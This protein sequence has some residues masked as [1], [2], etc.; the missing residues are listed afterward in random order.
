MNFQNV[1]DS[2]K[3]MTCIVSVEKLEG[4]GHGTIRIVTGNKAYIDSIE[5]PMDGVAMLTDKF[6]PNCEYTTYLPKDLNFEDFCYRSAVEKKCLHSYA[7]PDRFDVWF[8]MTFM[9][10]WPD[11]GNICYCTYSMEINQEADAARMSNISS[12]IAAAVLETCIMLRGTTNFIKTI[13]DIVGFVRSLCKGDR[14]CLITMDHVEKTVTVLGDDFDESLGVREVEEAFGDR[15]Y[16]IASTW[17]DTISGSNCLIV[18][19]QQEMEVVKERNPGWYESLV[20]AGVKTIVL[21]PLKYR[22]ELLGYMWVINFESSEAP[23]LK[24]ALEAASFILSSEIYNYLL[25][26]RLKTLSSKDMLTGVQN[27]NEMNNMVDSYVNGTAEYSDKSVGIIFADLNGLKAIN[28]NEGHVAGDEM[29]K[30]AAAVLAE[31]FDEDNIYRAGGDEFTIIAPGVTENDL[32]VKIDE[33]RTIAE[34]YEDVSFAMGYAVVENSA[35]IRT[36]LR[37]ADERMYVDKEAYYEKHPDKR[38]DA[39]R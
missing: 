19:D 24:E 7:H 29:L 26:G 34:K 31:V 9:P 37:K 14:C 6:V 22:L 30:D 16:E 21:F 27:R 38:R 39:T 11:D 28:D 18:K 35:E 2:I 3:A 33:V 20:A 1:A 36:A 15:F 4:G 13:G 5:H 10:L 17:E 23:R 8:N 25:L 12:D 32:A